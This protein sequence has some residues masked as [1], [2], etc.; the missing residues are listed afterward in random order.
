MIPF[1][2]IEQKPELVGETSLQKRAEHPEAARAASI[3]GTMFVQ[4]VVSTCGQTADLQ[5][6]RSS[7]ETL[8]TEALRVVRN[9]TFEPARQG[10]QAVSVRMSVPIRCEL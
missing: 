6:L 7:G 10:G 8:S 5:V 4:S 1:A 3:E 9:A 2:V